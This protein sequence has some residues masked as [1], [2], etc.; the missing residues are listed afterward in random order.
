V[1]EK[2]GEVRMKHVKVLSS[3]RPAKA[4]ETSY[5]TLKEVITP[6]G[7]G[8]LSDAASTWLFAMWDTYLQK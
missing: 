5:I 6:G 1:K 2:G 3:E 8:T 4:D 7:L